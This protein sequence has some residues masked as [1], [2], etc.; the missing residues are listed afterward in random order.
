VPAIL[1]VLAFTLAF[2]FHG[3]G[4]HVGT[5]FDWQGLALAGLAFL[6]WHATGW[7]AAPAWVPRRTV[8]QQPPA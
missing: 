1:A 3:A 2:A 6:A 8:V 5:W 4:V 7:W